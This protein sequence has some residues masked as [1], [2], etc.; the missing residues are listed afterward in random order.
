[1][2]GF[3]LALTLMFVVRLGATAFAQNAQS[4]PA[5]PTQAPPAAAV[6]QRAE[7]GQSL[8][9]PDALLDQGDVYYVYPGED[10]Q[11]TIMSDAALRRI[12]AT[13]NR[14]V[15]FIVVPFEFKAGT[16][17]IAGGAFRIP[18]ASLNT[19]NADIDG[20]IQGPMLLNASANP[21][22][23]FVVTGATPAAQQLTADK[24]VTTCDFKL[25]GQLTIRGVTK[26]VEWPARITFFPMN[27]KRTFMRYPGDF[28]VLRVKAD[29]T[30]GD[31]GYK[32]GRFPSADVLADTVSA[33]IAL[34]FNNI[35]IEKTLDPA[36]PDKDHE[37]ELQL[38][39][40]LRDFKDAAKGYD[41]AREQIKAARNN[42]VLLNRLAYVIA[43]EPG[44]QRRDL[45]LALEAATRANEVKK[46]DGALL[47]TLA[48]VHYEMGDLKTALD[49]QRQA[50]AHLDGVD[51][52]VTGSIRQA[53]ARYESEAK[54]SGMIAATDA[55]SSSGAAGTGK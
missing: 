26:D 46:D 20:L 30:L 3:T 18:I 24:D 14:V 39:T 8:V 49:T 5:A 37:R 45:K 31:F 50:V 53:L 55:P 35:P 42:A 12:V 4:A 29:L 11:L 52:Q 32:R 6:P 10:G 2:R 1:M 28:V 44:I 43:A 15:G 34:F 21:E 38:L 48:R 51:P 36:Y 9:V 13:C 27:V 23:T 19:G 22:A 17:P 41:F 16:K 40:L 33:D 7:S 47:D 54:A 25:L